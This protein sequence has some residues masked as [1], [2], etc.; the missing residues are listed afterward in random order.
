MSF[1]SGGIGMR[2]AASAGVVVALVGTA[3]AEPPQR[4]TVERVRPAGAIPATS[5]HYLYLNR[6][7]GGCT[8]TGGA[9]D[10][11]SL[12]SSI[13]APGANMM[14]EFHAGDPA[15]DA[16][17]AALVTCVQEVYS[18]FSITVSDQLPTNGV[19][20][21]EAVVAGNPQE[22]GLPTSYLGVGVVYPDC[23]PSDNIISF[24]FANHESGTGLAR[25]YDTCWTVAQETSHSFGLDHEYQFTDG[26]SACSDP[27][28]YRTDC[29]GEKFFR[30]K[31]AAC[32]E[33][34]A[35]TCKCGGVQNSVAKLTEVLGAGT[36]TIPA[37]TVMIES[38][39]A[40]TV[41]AGFAV[42]AAAGSRRGVAKVEMWL[43]NHLWATAA[44][45]PFGANGQPD[46]SDYT[47]T[48]PANVPNG[49]I[50]LVVKAYDDLDIETDSPTITLQM[51]AP[52]ATADSCLAGQKC[53]AG[54][55][56]W[57]APVGVLGDACTYNEYCVTGLCQQSDVGQF[58]TQNCVVG[59]S[60]GCP[61][62]FD[63]VATSDTGGVCLPQDKGGGGC[64][65]VDGYESNRAIW[66]HLGLGVLA[67]GFIVRRRRR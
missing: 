21:T 29:G 15:A 16:D 18:P 3:F 9:D 44:G 49:V 65:S 64:C 41:T 23:S 30:N 26:Q 53:E 57:D 24:S 34:V 8:I 20:F 51:G 35:R 27:M 52:C 12:S 46:P 7:T 56:F 38:P 66:A 6:C 42:H 10:A 1:M 62:M 54:K 32:G 4:A 22:I 36:S 5:S 50:D 55:C 33:Y 45:A 47:V 31:P 25:T 63:C 58:C 40:G 39:G 48:A 61:A 43:N 19:S 67:L 11:R 17:W 2:I 14:T 13:A 59:S 37:P 60:D 28:T